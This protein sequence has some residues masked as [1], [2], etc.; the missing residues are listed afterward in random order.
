MTILALD[1]S[2]DRGSVALLIDGQLALDEN[3]TAGR[4]HSAILF[5]VLERARAKTQHLDT[6]AV[7]LGPGSYAGV[8]I[9]IA[10]AIG[11]ELGMGARV[12]G[13]PSVAALETDATRYLAIGDA[14]RET[15][16]FTRVEGGQCLEGPLLVTESEL[17][18]RLAASG[19]WPVFA[20]AH[21]PAFPDARIALPSAALLAQLAAAGRS[22]AA[23][24]DLEPIYL[25]EPHITQPKPRPS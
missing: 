19:G 6:I 22:I 7:G 16:Y 8:R 24:G 3:F 1:T 4:S 2:T 23:E 17:R 18:E 15:F 11:L 5:A 20:P 21:L 13:I 10:A 25:R 14:R 9:A 12:V